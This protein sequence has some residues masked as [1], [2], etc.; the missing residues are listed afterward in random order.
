NPWPSNDNFDVCSGGVCSVYCPQYCYFLFPSPPASTVT[1]DGVFSPSIIALLGILACAFIALAYYAF[2]RRYI[3][4]GGGLNRDETR[5][6]AGNQWRMPPASAA[7][8]GGL[9]EVF[10][11]K[12]AV[13]RYGRGEELIDGTECAVCLGE[14]QQDEAL[15]LLPK[16][17][18]AFH[19]PCIDTWLKSH[20]SC[21]ICRGNI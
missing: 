4:Q 10:I 8:A 12:M 7:G 2:I 13:C 5:E 15:R 3:R 18:H 9:D 20:P 1:K 17:R 14:F 11:E 6:F 16:C 19:L 21:P